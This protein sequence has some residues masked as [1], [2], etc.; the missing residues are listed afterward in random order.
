MSDVTLHIKSAIYAGWKK[1]R[2]SSGVEQLAG[3]F[4]LSITERWSGQDGWPIV[5]GD[6]CQLRIDNVPVITGYVDDVL[7]TFAAT[8]HSITITGRDKTGDLVD[9]SAVHESGAWLNVKL[10]QIAKD[11]CRPFGIDVIVNSDVGAV[12][13]KFSIQQ[14]ET[15]FEA[16]DRAARMRGV[17]LTSDGL[18][19]LVITRVG[20]DRIAT[21]LVQGQNIRGGS[22]QL[23]HRSRFQSYTVKGMQSGD[24]WSSP[25]QNSQPVAT[26]KDPNIKR[27]RP[28]VL[29]AENS[30]D[31]AAMAQRANWE[32]ATRKGRGKRA[33]ITV[34]GWQHSAGL[35]LPNY[36]VAV[37]CPYL[38]LHRDMLLAGVDYIVDDEG[39][40]C[41]LKLAPPEAFDV[42]PLI[43]AATEE[44]AW[45]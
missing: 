2:I 14:G 17:L 28:I 38:K 24:D 18:G 44:D 27:Y 31:Q 40:R 41:E 45:A 36:V 23:S 16:L 25:E 37:D 35:W 3:R 7:P 21:A 30:G 42:Q 39:K 4:N 26:A 43:E 9:C 1:I 10:D 8:S 29:I 5:C 11:L 22:G 32:A 33:T 6:A 19:N 13:K 20:T 12:F 15:V 34:G